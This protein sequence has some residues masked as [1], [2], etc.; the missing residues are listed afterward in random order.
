MGFAHE[1]LDGV[2]FR[3]IN[4][5][6]RQ[7]R[8]VLVFC[9]KAN[10]IKIHANSD[11]YDHA[12]GQLINMQKTSSATKAIKIP[13]DHHPRK[14]RSWTTKRRKRSHQTR[15]SRRWYTNFNHNLRFTFYC[16]SP[17]SPNNNQ[18]NRRD[19]ATWWTHPPYSKH[20]VQDSENVYF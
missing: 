19:I 15:L 8:K 3:M 7:R 1:F 6:S 9:L 14:P 18:I 17:I 16:Q 12:H 5:N 11:W 4:F 13:L 20:Q 10:S 2:F